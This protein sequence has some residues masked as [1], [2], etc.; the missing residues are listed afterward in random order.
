MCISKILCGL[1][2]LNGLF[3]RSTLNSGEP[4][5][6]NTCVVTIKCWTLPGLDQSSYFNFIGNAVTVLDELIR[7]VD[8]KDD[9]TLRPFV[10]GGTVSELICNKDGKIIIPTSLQKRILTWYHSQLV[11]PGR[12]WLFETIFQQFDWPKAGQLRRKSETS[13]GIA[14]HVKFPKDN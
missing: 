14:T 9:L 4:N 8:Q 13:S 11:H 3:S 12:D 2:P 6:P 7:R 5:G 1:E 10:G